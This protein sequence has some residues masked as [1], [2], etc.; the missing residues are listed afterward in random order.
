MFYATGQPGW[1]RYGGYAAPEIDPDPEMEKQALKSQ[2]DYLQ[3]EL[4]TI[5]KRLEAVEKEAEKEVKKK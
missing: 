5:R 1:M 2:A 4:D 3:N